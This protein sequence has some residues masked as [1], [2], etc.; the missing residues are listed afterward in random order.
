M[1]SYFIDQNTWGNVWVF[2]PGCERGTLFASREEAE[3]FV[4]QR[5]AARD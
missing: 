5:L 4:A 3:H 1:T 2:G